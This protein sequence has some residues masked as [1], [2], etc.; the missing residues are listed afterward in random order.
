MNALGNE[1]IENDRL[2]PLLNK[3]VAVWLWSIIFGATAGIGYTTITYRSGSWGGLGAI[4]VLP[5][6]VVFVFTAAA[7]FQLY[8]AFVRYLL[9]VFF[10][11]G[12][13]EERTYQFRYSL[14]RAFSFLFMATLIRI[15]GWIM[16]LGLNALSR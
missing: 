1:R 12:P 3:Y 9:P 13:T 4:I 16:E 15:L 5:G 11:D 14:A 7:W 10:G 8:K 6:I 2:S